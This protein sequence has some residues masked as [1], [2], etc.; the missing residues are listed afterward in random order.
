MGSGGFLNW[1]VDSL[2]KRRIR[3]DK[4]A[5]RNGGG[6]ALPRDRAFFVVF[7]FGENVNLEDEREPRLK[8]KTSI[9]NLSLS[10]QRFC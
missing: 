3:F 10:F 9:E 1:I 7:F 8:G 5:L 2:T 6:R 4:C